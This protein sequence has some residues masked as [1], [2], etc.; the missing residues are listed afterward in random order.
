MIYDRRY[1]LLRLSFFASI[2]FVFVLA[3]KIAQRFLLLLFSF[4]TLFS[5][6]ALLWHCSCVILFS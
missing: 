6:A 2:L 1:L 5:Y 3:L 4:G